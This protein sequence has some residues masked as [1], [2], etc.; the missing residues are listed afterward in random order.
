[1]KQK[2]LCLAKQNTEQQLWAEKGNIITQKNYEVANFP[3]L[4]ET[5]IAPF[6]EG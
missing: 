5:R 6:G 3:S 4:M 2:E 1:M